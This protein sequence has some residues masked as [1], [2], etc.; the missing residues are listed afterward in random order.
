VTSTRRMPD[1]T[2]DAARCSWVESANQAGTDFPVQNLPFG[3]ALDTDGATCV[4]AIGDQALDLGRLAAKGL[5]PELDGVRI[6]RETRLNRLLE[7]P[8]EE[9]TALRHRIAAILS[10]GS[11]EESAVIN[12]GAL[13]PLADLDLQTPTSIASFTD[14]Y[15]GIFHAREG[16]R[17]MLGSGSELPAH[18]RWVPVAYQSRAGTVSVSGRPVRR[19]R[20]QLPRPNGIP[21][22]LPCEMLDFELELGFYIA[23]DTAP[24]EPV[25]IGTAY[26]RISG[27]C[28]L[29]DWSARD[30]QRWEMAPLG[31]FLA[32]SFATTVSS[33]IITP[34]ALVPFRIPAMSRGDDEPAPLPHL[35]DAADQ[36]E[37]GLAVE[38][39]VWLRTAAMR[40]AG[41]ERK[42]LLQSDARHL[43]WTP[44]QMVA[45]HTSNGCDL[46]AG[47]LIGTGTI[48]G[49]HV[50]QSGSLLELTEDGRSPTALSD[51]E[52]RGYLKDGDEVT[53]TGRCSR[54][55]FKAIGFGECTAEVLPA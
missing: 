3:C 48:S 32:K 6:D 8:A 27:F 10:R 47:D 53:L 44:A 38:L 55:G 12:T 22:Y 16:A 43:Y 2:H 11:V 46:R 13:R 4:V 50:A 34:D 17:V 31:P 45:H 39:S 24:G 35:H 25:P 19:P 5:L 37:G 33:W 20:G 18:Y 7:K 42:L 23:T 21:E 36:V 30:I 26:E 52:L 40:A 29:N 1:D 28:L 41:L 14:F 49:P 15:A 54:D 51:G 9:L